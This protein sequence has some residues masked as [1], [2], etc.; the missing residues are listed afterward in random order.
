MF[1]DFSVVAHVTEHFLIEHQYRKIF[2]AGN[3]FHARGHA[4]IVLTD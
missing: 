2:T 1:G 3:N 4:G